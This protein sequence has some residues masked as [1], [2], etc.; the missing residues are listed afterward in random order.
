[1]VYSMIILL[2]GMIVLV[3]VIWWR[4]ISKTGYPGA[5]SLLMFVPVAN[6]VLIFIL[7]FSEWPV[8]RENRLLKGK[9]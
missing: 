9:R 3:V 7:A 5:L 8:E 4:I 1:M 6:V 2:L